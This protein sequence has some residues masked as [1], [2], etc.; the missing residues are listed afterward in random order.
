MEEP[1]ISKNIF[2]FLH[3]I[4]NDLFIKCLT[5]SDIIFHFFVFTVNLDN[6]I[7]TARYLAF[8]EYDLK[9]KKITYI[10]RTA[11]NIIAVRIT[12]LNHLSLSNFYLCLN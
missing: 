4:L 11:V 7:P 10:L 2:I 1:N 12:A 8:T 3:F 9:G 6:S 5:L